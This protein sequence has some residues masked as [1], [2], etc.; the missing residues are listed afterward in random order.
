MKLHAALVPIGVNFVA[1]AGVTAGTFYQKRFIH[2]GDLR[3]VAALQYVGALAAGI[4]MAA[5]A[6]EFR[7][8]WTPT[9]FAVLAWSVLALSIGAIALLLLLIRRGEISRSAQLI[10]LVSLEIE[11]GDVVEH[12]TDITGGAGTSEAYETLRRPARRCTA[13]QCSVFASS[14]AA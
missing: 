7:I 6:G 4:P 2:T 8:N 1:M 11:R 13:A 12:Q 5:L 10:F 9:A 14:C 3:T